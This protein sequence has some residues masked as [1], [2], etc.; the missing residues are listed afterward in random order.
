M[1]PHV[2]AALFGGR[3]GWSILKGSRFGLQSDW[4]RPGD[5][6]YSHQPTVGDLSGTGWSGSDQGP[7][8]HT[9]G[10]DADLA[11][12]DALILGNTYRITYT[13]TADSDAG[14][15]SARAGTTAG[16]DRDASGTFTDQLMCAGNTTLAFTPSADFDGSI[17]IESVENISVI[18]AFVKGRGTWAGSKFTQSAAANMPYWD[19]GLNFDGINKFMPHSGPPEKLHTPDGF[20]AAFVIEPEITVATGN[21]VILDQTNN[22]PT[23]PGIQVVYSAATQQ[24]TTRVA[25]GVDWTVTGS[26]WLS[27][28][29]PHI[30]DARWSEAGGLRMSVDDH[31][32]EVE[33][34]VGGAGAAADLQ[35]GRRVGGEY[36]AGRVSDLVVRSGEVPDRD[37]ERW[38]G[39]MRGKLGF[40]HKTFLEGLEFATSKASLSGK[41][42]VMSGYP[43]SIDYGDGTVHEFV[44]TGDTVPFLY[45]Y[46]EPGRHFVRLTCDPS[47]LVYLYIQDNGFAGQLPLLSDYTNLSLYYIQGNP[48]SGPFPAVL[49]SVSY[50]N[51][52]GANYTG[53]Y[54]DFPKALLALYGNASGFSGTIPS[55]SRCTGVQHAVFHSNKLT[56]YTPSVI[57]TSLANIQA[58]NNLLPQSAIDQIIQDVCTNLSNRPTTGTLDLGG[59]GNAAPSAAGK[60]KAQEIKEHGW[61]VTVNGGLD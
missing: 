24:L 25:N 32:V 37:I 2:F 58:S 47:A 3:R 52:S 16:L 8:Q 35:L 14:S 7:Y 21:R 26:T 5:V 12:P 28:G 18:E 29:I 56:G 38:R 48:L 40:R 41:L 39:R 13:V 53:P 15:V 1:D 27:R 20:T 34:G 42:R 9:P 50:L 10:S 55:L 46:N 6:T 11:Q 51:I 60:A 17:T 30:V 44:G 57:A 61:T 54:P 43:Y 19:N 23:N 45:E 31:S 36:F 59:A 4:T 49:D 22:D 33:G